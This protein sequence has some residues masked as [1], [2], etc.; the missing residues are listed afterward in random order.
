N[1]DRRSFGPD[2][3]FYCAREKLS[4]TSSAQ[5]RS[6]QR[7]SA[8]AMDGTGRPGS[9][10]VDS[11][12]RSS[13]RPPLGSA[14]GSSSRTTTPPPSSS[15]GRSGL[16]QGRKRVRNEFGSPSTARPQG[17]APQYGSSFSGSAARRLFSE[18]AKASK[19]PSDSS[20]PPIAP[21]RKVVG[22]AT[23]CS[24]SFVRR[25]LRFPDLEGN[26][27]FLHPPA[28]VWGSPSE[29]RDYME[30]LPAYTI[31]AEFFPSLQL[32]AAFYLK[33]EHVQ[34]LVSKPRVYP[35]SDSV[36]AQDR[37][38]CYRF[39][40]PYDIPPKP[41]TTVCLDHVPVTALEVVSDNI[42]KELSPYV[43]VH[44]ISPR[45]WA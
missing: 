34:K 31:G 9:P 1:L 28:S 41:L 29:L 18:V 43:I 44:R 37:T 7:S 3:L 21:F 39:M 17:A 30:G 12:L 36:L 20:A 42:L 40:R 4:T 22:D 33:I 5:D 15:A 38:F 27:A 19:P 25:S 8:T 23:Y 24:D 2:E 32:I 10:R 11:T 13:S 26:V 6:T 16:D 35:R 45:E 14:S